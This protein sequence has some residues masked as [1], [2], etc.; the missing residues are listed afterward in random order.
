MDMIYKAQAP[1][2]RPIYQASLGAILC[3]KSLIRLQKWIYLNFR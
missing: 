1:A 3:I 2:V